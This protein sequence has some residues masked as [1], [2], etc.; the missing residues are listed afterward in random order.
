MSDHASIISALTDLSGAPSPDLEIIATSGDL[1][2]RAIRLHQHDAGRLPMAE[3]EYDDEESVVHDGGRLVADMHP[4][5]RDGLLAKAR[6]VRVQFER[7]T[8]CDDNHTVESI[9]EYHER[10]A[11]SLINDLLHMLGGLDGLPNFTRAR[12]SEPQ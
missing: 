7:L 2:Q 9:G 1:L 8:A 11:W 4:V 5:T 10:L 3:D 12:K 6:F